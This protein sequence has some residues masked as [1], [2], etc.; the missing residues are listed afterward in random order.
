M[1]TTRAPGTELV[2]GLPVFS[3]AVPLGS[4]STQARNVTAVVDA[5]RCRQNCSSNRCSRSSVDMN[6]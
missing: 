4:P 5:S 6:A 1:P 2:L 3:S